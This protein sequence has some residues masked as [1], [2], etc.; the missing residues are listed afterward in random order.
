M[1][2]PFESTISGAYRFGFTRIL[3]V[4]GIVWF[5]VLLMFAIMGGLF[6]ALA[7]AFI[8]F[9]K[10]L[11]QEGQPADPVRLAAFLRAF[12]TA[13]AVVL[14]VF[15]IGSAIARVGVMR[16]ALGQIEGPVF[17]FFSLGGQVWRLVGAYIL[18]MLAAWALGVAFVIGGAAL[19]YGLNAAAPALATLIVTLGGI[20]AGCFVIYAFVR[21]Y[22]FLPAIVVAENTIGLG[23]SW[24]LGRGNFWR[25]VGIVLMIYRPVSFAIGIVNSTIM[26]VTVMPTVLQHAGAAQTP[27]E[28]LAVMHEMFGAFLR[29]LPYFIGMQIVQMVLLFGIDGGAVATAYKLVTEAASGREGM[30]V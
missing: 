9:F 11:P 24:E 25:I 13:Y 30:A 29:Y 27:A 18:L 2:I 15:V 8:D 14:P 10:H 23:R 7:P 4:I 6:Y 17:F 26:Q 21:T 28:N 19:W 12:F 3:T 5:P 22:F 20:A 1:H 16:A